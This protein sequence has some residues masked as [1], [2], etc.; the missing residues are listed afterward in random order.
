MG[1]ILLQVVCQAKRDDLFFTNNI[2]KE[3][4]TRISI[5]YVYIIIFN[6]LWA[7]IFCAQNAKVKQMYKSYHDTYLHIYYEASVGTFLEQY[8]RIAISSVFSVSQIRLIACG[9]FHLF[10][11]MGD[12]FRRSWNQ[13]QWQWITI[14]YSWLWTD[15]NPPLTRWKSFH[16]IG[17][18]YSISL[19]GCYKIP[20]TLTIFVGK[21]HQ[22]IQK[23]YHPIL[24]M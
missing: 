7:N 5:I 10:L 13:K 12:D 14:L 23:N 2:C 11:R 20:L 8:S 15:E 9:V 21:R 1:P 19:L 16:N 22:H 4:Q 17:L 18:N 3:V 6:L 24:D